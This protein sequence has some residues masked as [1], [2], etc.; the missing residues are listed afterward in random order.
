MGTLL[1][2]RQLTTPRP[3]AEVPEDDRLDDRVAA[4][5]TA[6]SS[7]RL[8]LVEPLGEGGMGTVFRAVDGFGLACR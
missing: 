7:G 3:V 6:Y 2:A 5:L 4:D 1:Q 8:R